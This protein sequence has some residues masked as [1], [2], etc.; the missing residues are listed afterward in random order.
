MWSSVTWILVVFFCGIVYY[1]TQRGF[2]FWF[3]DEIY[4]DQLESLSSFGHCA[5]STFDVLCNLMLFYFTL[6]MYCNF[7]FLL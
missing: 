4:G 5:H 7:L 2:K 6:V 1:A 3:C